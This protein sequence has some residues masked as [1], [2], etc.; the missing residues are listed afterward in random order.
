MTVSFSTLY[1]FNTFLCG[2]NRDINVVQ[3]PYLKDKWV[4]FVLNNNYENNHKQVT[5]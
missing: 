5:E 4:M 2:E 3:R 1:F